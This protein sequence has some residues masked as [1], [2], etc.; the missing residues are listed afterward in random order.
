MTDRLVTL[1]VLV[2]LACLA[3]GTLIG[4]IYLTAIDKSL[5]GELIAI[6][7]SAAGAIAGILS[8][9]SS[10]GVRITNADDD[11]VPVDAG[12]SDLETALLVGLAA[13]GLV[14]LLFILL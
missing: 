7:S 1:V 4:G 2:S 10:D 8:R 6:G 5:P 13:F 3:V 14:C 12:R 11:P 9:P